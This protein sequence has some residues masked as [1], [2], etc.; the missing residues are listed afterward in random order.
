M[1]RAHVPL[2]QVHISSNSFGNKTPPLEISMLEIFP[3]KTGLTMAILVDRNFVARNFREKRASPYGYSGPT[4]RP[5]LG[6]KIP[7]RDVI[8]DANPRVRFC[9]IV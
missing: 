4:R 6:A 8:M 2:N 5:R 3:G 7:K 9:L 1:D